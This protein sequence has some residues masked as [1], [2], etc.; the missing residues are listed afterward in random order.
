MILFT[1]GLVKAV[2]MT[3]YNLG[4]ILKINDDTVDV[5]V[6]SNV[7][8]ASIAGDKTIEFP[9]SPVI[10]TIQLSRVKKLFFSIFI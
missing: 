8:S 2:F 10:F 9:L 6:A 5:E 7:V 4:N 3:H 1:D